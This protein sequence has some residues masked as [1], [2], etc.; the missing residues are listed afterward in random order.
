MIKKYLTTTAFI[1]IFFTFTVNLLNAQTS[2]NK[3][4]AQ[5]LSHLP[6]GCIPQEFPN[7]TSHLSDGPDD[8][9]LLPHQLHPVFF[10]CLDWH[11]ALHG[12]WM[13]VRL[14]KLYPDIN[15]RDS[16]IRLLDNSF[17]IEK[18]KAEALYFGK[19]TASASFE[20]TY[21]WA[22]LLKL[23]E[24]LYTWQDPL[25][26][27][28]HTALQP[29]TQKIL[30]L[31]Q[32]YLPKQTYPNRT[33]THGNTAFA[34]SFAYDWAIATKDAG[35]LKTIKEKAIYFYQSNQ[36][37]PGYLE[38]DGAD[39][40]SPSLMAADLMSKV[41]SRQ[42]FIKWLENYYEP[43]SINRLYQIP[44]VSDRNDYQIV[45]LDGL[46]FSRA[47]NFLQIAKVLPNNHRY[48]LK[49]E[50]AAKKYLQHSLP[51]IFNGGYGGEHWLA[52]FAVYA[53]SM[54]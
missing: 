6:M 1:C 17:Q 40:F 10:G 12:H 3:Q 19:Y 9:I 45:H 2:L 18:M 31:W 35:F 22:W 43:R 34:L 13:L 15:N 54:Q 23:D 36:K 29:L 16:I 14:L 37:M 24:E 27:K 48:K 25:A 50:Q 49:F 28:W 26:K 44:T 8:A 47:W 7:K 46:S 42:N 38:P 30:K 20:R 41:L 53:L 32:A 39:F 4:V 52:S 33:G 21:G 11:S 5:Q 51:H